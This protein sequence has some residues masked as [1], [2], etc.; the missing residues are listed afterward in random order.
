MN[1]SATIIDQPLVPVLAAELH[2]AVGGQGIEARAADLHHGH[3]ERAAAEIVDQN[4]LRLLRRALRVQEALLKAEGDGRGGRL[5][6]DVEHLEARHV[7]GVLRRL[8]ADFVEIGRHRD[9]H[10][11]DRPELPLGVEP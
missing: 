3:V 4:L 1:S 6:D 7:A 11:R 5:V 2:V 10:L 9:D 8:A